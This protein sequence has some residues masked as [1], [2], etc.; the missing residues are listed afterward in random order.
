MV[1][2]KTPAPTTPAPST[3]QS[4]KQAPSLS[5]HQKPATGETQAQK[6]IR[7]DAIAARRHRK[8]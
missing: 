1:D 3:A 6:K 8:V 5:R 7:K 2:I 4:I